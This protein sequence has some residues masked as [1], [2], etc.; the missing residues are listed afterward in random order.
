VP[1]SKRI[2]L[3]LLAAL[4]LVLVPATGASATTPAPA[5]AAPQGSAPSAAQSVPRIRA[6]VL[7]PGAKGT[8]VRSLQQILVRVGLKVAVSGTYHQET[9]TAVQRF[10]IARGLDASG[11]AGPA[12]IR[13][14][15]AAARGP[16]STSAAGGL[17]FGE[18]AERIR[19]LGDRI[20]L[21]AGMSGADV[22]QLQAFLRRAGVRGAPRPTG[23]YGAQTA[24]AVRRYERGERRAVDGGLDAGD[25]YALLSDVGE[26]GTGENP[27]GTPPP[28]P[29]APGE[30]ARVRADGI[31]V[32]PEGAPEAVKR[33][34]AAGNQIAKMPYKWGGGHGRWI[35]SGY[36]CSGSV[37]FALRGAG[38][39][40]GGALPSYGFYDWGEAGA[41]RWVTIYTNAGHMYMVVAGIRFDTSGRGANR[42]RWQTAM[43]DSSSF[44][45]R[46]PAGL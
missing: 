18:G 31:A 25:I 3:P 43:R 7:R 30:R 10:Q 46:H 40:K 5:A 14:L 15:R 37:S 8:P 1:H 9:A 12:T 21:V 33:I 22:R 26:D 4:A 36:D 17:G 16:R 44:K 45:V 32:A 20:P 39:M 13:A 34:I 28:P 6:A 35:D 27:A 42:S 23:E 38:F 19:R 24:A 11:V 41:G 29:L 2:V